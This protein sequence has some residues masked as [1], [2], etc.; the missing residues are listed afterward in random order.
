[1]KK[2]YILA[3]ILATVTGWIVILNITAMRALADEKALEIP[4]KNASAETKKSSS[5]I[6]G[7]DTIPH[8]DIQRDCE[9]AAKQRDRWCKSPYEPR[10]CDD[11]KNPL[12]QAIGKKDKAKITEI[13]KTLLTRQTHGESC[14]EA[15]I[16][17][18]HAFKQADG[19]VESDKRNFESKRSSAKN[20]EMKGFFTDMIGYAD[21]ILAYYNK[22]ERGHVD[23]ITQVRTLVSG[24]SE[25]VEKADD[26]LR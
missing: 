10:N 2:F 1:M 5:S 16:N 12:T 4:Y 13:R 19:R 15:R 3:L 9:D 6:K 26:A 18:Q 25:Q 8:S 21:L 11:Q 14:V 20:A 7:C 17:V 24:C 22:E 23:Q